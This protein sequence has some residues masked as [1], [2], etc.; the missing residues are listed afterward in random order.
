MNGLAIAFTIATTLLFVQSCSLSPNI[1]E[2]M[3]SSTTEHNEL[4]AASANHDGHA[5]DR[6]TEGEKKTA[7][8][9][10]LIAP[11]KI[12][13]NTPVRLSIEIRD[14]NGNAIANFDTF[15]EELMHLIMVSDD[16][17]SFAHLHPVYNSNGR[18][19]VEARFPKPGSYTFFSDYK[20]MGQQEQVSVL[21]TR[22]SG[23]RP[24][25]VK[26]NVNRTKTFADTKVNLELSQATVKAGEEVTLMFD[27]QDAVSDQPVTDLQPYLGEK[28][29]LVILRQS[30]PLTSSDYVHAHALKDTPPGQVHFAT[31][32]PRPGQ[33]KLWG[34]FNRN[35]KIVTADFWVNVVESSS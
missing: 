5:M 4:A 35:G 31:R 26:M 18:F 22:V 10:K 8:K 32:F 23:E 17:Q 12:A 33:Y 20:P 29:H 9:A 28:G 11:D 27:L 16:L 6:A 1:R 21:K 25:A 24:P 13:P 14:S 34:Q 15:Q 7:A 19:E 3:V 2:T 30:S